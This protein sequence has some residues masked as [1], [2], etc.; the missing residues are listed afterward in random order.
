MAC[1]DGRN[2]E[3]GR[4]IAARVMELRPGTEPNTSPAISAEAKRSSAVGS[5]MS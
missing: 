4:K 3:K 1:S 5:L 2:T